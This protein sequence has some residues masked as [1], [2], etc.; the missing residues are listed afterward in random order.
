MR[1]GKG[2]VMIDEHSETK[3]R[4]RV[5]F[6]RVHEYFS[7]VSAMGWNVVLVLRGGLQSGNDTIKP[8][9]VWSEV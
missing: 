9:S 7:M 1:S 3:W 5:G 6:D 8:C 2:L 4:E